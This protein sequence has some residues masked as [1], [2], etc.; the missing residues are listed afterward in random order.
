MT[1][2][3]RALLLVGV[4]A[5][6]GFATTGCELL[7]NF[8]RSL[9]PSDG[10]TED[11]S[12]D[13]SSDGLPPSEDAGT[14]ST[15]PT[16]AS[17]A[18]I[19]DSSDAAVDTGV[20]TG[21]GDAGC[22]A[23]TG[24]AVGQACDLGNHTCTSSCS[25]SQPCNGTCCSAASSGTCETTESQTECSA[26]G[27]AVCTTCVGNTTAGSA[28]VISGSGPAGACGC[29]EPTDCPVNESC[30]TTTHTCTA[31]CGP[32]QPCNTGCCADEDGGAGT[33]V[34]GTASGVC[35][36]SGGSCT[37]CAGNSVGDA[38]LTTTG[39][40]QRRPVRHGVL[41][42]GRVQ[43]LVL[44][45]PRRRH[46]RLL[47]DRHAAHVLRRGGRC[48]PRLREQLGRA[49]LRQQRLRVHRSRRLPLG[50]GVR[51][52]EHVHLGV[53]LQRA[54][55]RHVLRDHRRRRGRLLRVR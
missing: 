26:V 3:N 10:G 17:D 15:L 36:A 8:D 20:D 1:L 41:R 48:V 16:D 4:F 44:R 27:T 32:T 49:H 22:S 31:A 42:V 7:V 21:T 37:S 40:L 38:C 45:H 2:R 33:C 13:A 14:D 39:G 30:N 52:P 29:N 47:C 19:T 25:S 54:L 46:D 18:A 24:C 28:C 11:G 34:V 5:F 55:Q 6:A 23:A 50:H 35:G 9:I 51:S 53:Q 12:V 43:R